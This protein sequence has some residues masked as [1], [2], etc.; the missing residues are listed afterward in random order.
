M[1]GSGKSTP[2]MMFEEKEYSF[3]LR[4][5]VARIPV[6]EDDSVGNKLGEWITLWGEKYSSDLAGKQYSVGREILR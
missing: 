3:P 6:G 4:M 5:I 1:T 2:G